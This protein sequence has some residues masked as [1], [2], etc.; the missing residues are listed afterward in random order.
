MKILLDGRLISEKP[1]G[2]SRY[3]LELIKMYQ[4]KFGYKNVSVLVNES[5]PGASYKEIITKY[6]PFNLFHFFKFNKFL[7]PI[8]F[9]LYHSLYYSNSF[10]KI[11]GKIYIT[12][13]HDLMYAVVKTFFGG[14]VF[15][16]FLKRLYF[17]LL[18]SRTLKN[19]DYIISV[20]DTTREDVKSRFGYDSIF[21]PEGI[22]VINS[23]KDVD[24]EDMGLERDGYILYVGNSRPHKNLERTIE[25]FLLSESHKTL[26]LCGNNNNVII[27][28]GSN[29]RQLGFV[30][31]DE[32]V[33]LYKNSSAFVFP[34][35]YEG[36]GLPVL[37]AL[38]LGTKVLSSTGGALKEFPEEVIYYFD[39]TNVKEI[40]R[41]FQNIDDISINHKELNSV[42]NTYS[43]E[44]CET[45]MIRYWTKWGIE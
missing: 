45:I 35:L 20:S 8:N 29:I 15:T 44:N 32:L 36:F 30:S 43:W 3:S 34:S 41:A 10:F 42:L 24:I 37:E 12:T 38:T 6:R 28:E 33:A 7:K 16:N 18:V 13:V 4:K 21:I 9:N 27:P 5:I 22:N 31:E 39:P 26:V 25:A 14:N 17:D 19:S 1:T 11:K 23:D 2:I 40:V